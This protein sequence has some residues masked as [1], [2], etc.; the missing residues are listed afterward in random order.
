MEKK[1]TKNFKFTFKSKRPLNADEKKTESVKFTPKP[2]NQ[3]RSF[4]AEENHKEF[5]Q[6]LNEQRDNY[7][8][9]V[10][11][12]RLCEE[13]LK[14]EKAEKKDIL[15]DIDKLLKST[16]NMISAR[17]MITTGHNTINRELK[18][19]RVLNLNY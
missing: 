9:Q 15:K 10:K 3:K 19:L 18:N 14:K 11:K 17:S 8:R 16:N 5:Y 2:K 7:D 1:E 13:E 6:S 4:D 12:I